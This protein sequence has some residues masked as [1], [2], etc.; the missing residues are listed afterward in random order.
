MTSLK[1]NIA[2]NIFYQILTILLPLITAPYVSRVLGAEGVGIYSYSYSI[3]SYFLLFTTLGISNHGNRSIAQC[4]KSKE[5]LGKC[6][7][8]NYIIQLTVGTVVCVIYAVYACFFASPERRIYAII[9]I[10]TV[11]SGVLDINWFFWGLE[12]FKLTV[13]RNTVCKII[14]VACIFIFVRES[15]DL[16]KYVLI[17]S[18]SVFISQLLLWH[19]IRREISFARPQ[20]YEVKNN[21]KSI[22]VLFIPI[23]AYSI[24][25]VMDKV[26]IGSF[27]TMTEVGY[28]ENAEKILNIPVG[29]VTALGNVMLP[30]ISNLLAHGEEKKQKE[31]IG[32][33]FTFVSIV[34]GAIC[35]GIAAVADVFVPIYY[36][37]EFVKSGDILSI[38]IFTALISGWAN[39]IRTQFL[40]PKKKDTIYVTSMVL[41][42]IVNGL[43]NLFFIPQ[44]GAMGAVVGTVTAEVI[45]L[46][47]QAICTR[48]ELN[49]FKILK[50]NIAYICIGVCMFLVVKAARVYLPTSGIITLLVEILIGVIVY[51]VLF[52]IYTFASKNL[53]VNSAKKLY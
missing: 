21:I 28:Y 51:G 22:C 20:C 39:V 42:A 7:I 19:F 26:M 45:V 14:S 36:G 31:Y 37:N 3:A 12:K 48:H 6:F 25:R 10:I 23:L 15:N 52:I 13:T 49:Y 24:Y 29:I 47:V 46:L 38:I 9:Q 53:I 1:K 27:S 32:M 34:E 33:S 17:M 11:L 43:L 40:I 8:N 5:A 18:L 41:A 44:Y 50:N 2:Y 35:F 30:R 16:W 4:E